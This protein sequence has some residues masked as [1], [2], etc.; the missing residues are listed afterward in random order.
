MLEL[1]ALRE[2]TKVLEVPLTEITCDVTLPICTAKETILEVEFATR[3][4]LLD[5]SKMT[6]VLETSVFPT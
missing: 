6:A 5:A 4:T 1:E 2:S 3:E